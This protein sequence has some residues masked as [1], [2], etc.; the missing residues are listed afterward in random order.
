MSYFLAGDGVSGYAE[1]LSPAKSEG[2]DLPN[3]MILDGGG[4]VRVAENAVGGH[5]NGVRSAESVVGGHE[6]GVRT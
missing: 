1:S 6:N 3:R 4:C 5:E 2:F